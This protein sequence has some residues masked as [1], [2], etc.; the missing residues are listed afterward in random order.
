M[1]VKERYKVINH[2]KRYYSEAFN[3]NYEFKKLSKR[4]LYKLLEENKHST[5][6]EH[7]YCCYGLYQCCWQEPYFEGNWGMSQKTVNEIIKDV[8]DRTTKICRKDNRILYYEDGIG[9]HMI[10]IARDVMSNDY[11]IT[12]TNKEWI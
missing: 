11:L 4:A 9:V 1:K 12:F 8:I 2:A 6:T 7:S 3:R 5:M 10:I